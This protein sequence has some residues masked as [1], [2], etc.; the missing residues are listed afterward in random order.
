MIDNGIRGGVA[1]IVKRYAKA[2]KPHLKENYNPAEPISY[3]VYLDANNLYGWAMSQYL[4]YSGFQWV[5]K[6]EWS[7]IQW[8]D[9]KENDDIGFFY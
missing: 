3:I 6:Q 7:K 8:I 4:P 2:N 9:L 5:E 1:M